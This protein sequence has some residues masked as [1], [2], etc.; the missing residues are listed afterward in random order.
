MLHNKNSIMLLSGRLLFMLHLGH[1]GSTREA[2]FALSSPPPPPPSNSIYETTFAFSHSW[3]Y[4][5]QLLIPRFVQ[6]PLSGYYEFYAACDDE[7]EVWI[8]IV[9]MRRTTNQQERT[10]ESEKKRIVKV[11]QGQW[12]APNQW[13]KYVKIELHGQSIKFPSILD[14]EKPRVKLCRRTFVCRHR[15]TYLRIEKNIIKACVLSFNASGI[16][17]RNLRL[18]CWASVMCTG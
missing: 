14:V 11:K 12:T 17:A 5:A 8:N 4:W 18:C 15:P 2:R 9:D 16:K 1:L 3:V 13:D 7:C 10:G 6:I